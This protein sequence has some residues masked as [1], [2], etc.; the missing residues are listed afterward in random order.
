MATVLVVLFVLYTPTS[1]SASS[2]MLFRSEMI[3]NCAFFV[4]SLM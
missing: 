4:R 1:R 3:T 2:N